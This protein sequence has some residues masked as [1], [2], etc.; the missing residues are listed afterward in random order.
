MVYSHRRRGSRRRLQRW[1]GPGR[2]FGQTKIQDF[3]LPTFGQKKICG[4]QVTMN[5]AGRVGNFDRVRNLHSEVQKLLERDG[6][7][8]DA[9]L[10]C[11]P[12]ETLHDDEQPVFV[13][14]DVVDS[15]DVRVVQR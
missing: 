2:D 14:T 12:F 7:S 13:F 3:R 5:N 10:Q 15:A 8:L 6:L 1:H 11:L 9:V 4:F